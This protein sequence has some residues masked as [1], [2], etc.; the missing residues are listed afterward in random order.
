MR[1]LLPDEVNHS[2]YTPR[3][4]EAWAEVIRKA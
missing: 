2:D 1:G 4:L 3:R